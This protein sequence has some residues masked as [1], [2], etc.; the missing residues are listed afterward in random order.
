[1]HVYTLK[2]GFEIV[3]LFLFV[4]MGDHPFGI[5]AAY[6]VDNDEIK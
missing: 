2:L 1:L 6:K 5:A 3:F 4:V